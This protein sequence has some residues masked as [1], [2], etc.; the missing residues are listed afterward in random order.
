[1]RHQAHVSDTPSSKGQ[2]EIHMEVYRTLNGQMWQMAIT[3]SVPVLIV[4]D[5]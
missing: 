2:E 4:T 3:A 5:L 1:M